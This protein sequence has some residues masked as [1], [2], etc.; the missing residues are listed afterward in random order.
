VNPNDAD[1][2][3]EAIRFLENLSRYQQQ[4]ADTRDGKRAELPPRQLAPL[5]GNEWGGL[6]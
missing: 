1:R 2:A 4:S 6:R 3:A 5:V